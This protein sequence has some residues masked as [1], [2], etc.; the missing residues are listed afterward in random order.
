[1]SV[2]TADIHFYRA[3]TGDSEGGAIGGTEITGTALNNFWPSVSDAE[4][5]AGGTRIR[6]WFLDNASGTDSLALPVVWVFQT[7]TYTTEYLGLGAN[8]ADDADPAQGNMTAWA[9]TA[10]VELVSDGADT[11]T[12]TITGRDGSGGPQSE[13][14]VL[15]G[16]TPADSISTYS[17]VYGVVLSGVSSSRTVL[18]KQGAAGTTRGTIGT[19]KLTCWLWVL[20]TTKGAGLALPTLGSGQDMGFWDKLVWSAGAGSIRPTQSVIAVEEGP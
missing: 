14:V 10:L 4:R 9:A 17:V 8:S 6:K 7:P 1:M 18:V 16:T 13:D 20:A 5:T 11:R 19:S 15:T 2:L 12:A 3:A